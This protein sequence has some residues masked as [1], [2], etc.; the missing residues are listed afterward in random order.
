MLSSGMAYRLIVQKRQIKEESTYFYLQKLF[1]NI[2]KEEVEATL[3]GY[4][5]KVLISLVKKTPEI[6][7]FIKDNQNLIL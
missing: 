3:L 6:Y 1:T 4:C 5:C 2:S 7:E